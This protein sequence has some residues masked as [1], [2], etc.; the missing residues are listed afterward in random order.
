MYHSLFNHSTVEG[1]LGFQQFLAVI[2]KA[3]VNIM[4]RFLC[5]WKFSFLWDKCPEGHIIA[6]HLIFLRNCQTVFQNGYT[7]LHSHQ[8]CMIVPIFLHLGQH[9]VN[10]TIIINVSILLGHKYSDSVFM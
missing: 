7:I 4:H 9:L 8:Q 1:N 2:H 5:E 10:P 6:G 3:T